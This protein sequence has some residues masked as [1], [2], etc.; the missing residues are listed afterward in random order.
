MAMAHDVLEYVRDDELFRLDEP[1]MEAR[2]FQY[3]PDYPAKPDHMY[4]EGYFHAQRSSEPLSGIN[5]RYWRHM[6]KP[7]AP[8]R[9]RAFIEAFRNKNDVWLLKSLADAATNERVKRGCGK[10]IANLQSIVAD[11]KHFAD[12]AV[13]VH[14]G[15][16]ISGSNLAWHSDAHNS[17]FHLG[18]SMRGSRALHT[19]SSP[20]CDTSAPSE[21]IEWQTPGSVYLT[22]AN[23]V[24]HAPEYPSAAWEDRIIAVQARVMLR[25]T[26]REYG[27]M[28]DRYDKELQLL[29][30]SDECWCQIMDF[31]AP[32]VVARGHLP[33]NA[34][35][36]TLQEVQAAE[37]GMQSAMAT[38]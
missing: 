32:A 20:T 9:L 38:P 35:I 14:F 25:P 18:I 23:M 8:V 27:D 17:I 3:H 10:S 2:G 11:G 31:I 29:S 19:L 15:S 34:T 36:P 5:P 26:V 12:V 13:Q 1:G 21:Q 30:Y 33:P 22:S 4:Y 16:E 24:V 37:G 28:V 6:Q 7:P